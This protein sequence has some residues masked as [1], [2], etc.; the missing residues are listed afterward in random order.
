[1]AGQ[2]AAA[3]ADALAGWSDAELDAKF[4]WTG[5]RMAR[6]I[7]GARAASAC[8]SGAAQR[9]KTGTSIPAPSG[10]GAGE[11]AKAQ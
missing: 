4:S 8:P 9:T 5:R 3:T 10:E 1:M 7:R 2:Q 6:S 11:S